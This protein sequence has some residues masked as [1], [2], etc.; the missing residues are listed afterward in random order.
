MSIQE[1]YLETLKQ[2]GY[3]TTV[4]EWAVKFGELHPDLLAQTHSQAVNQKRPSTGLKETAARMSS[5]IAK[6]V[7]KGKIEIDNSERPKKVR[8]LSED[9]ATQHILKEI[10]EDTEPLDRA[11]RIE[12]DEKRLTQKETYRI[13]EILDISKTMSRMFRLDFEVDHALALLHPKEPGAHH[14]DNMQILTKAHNGRKNNSNWAR[15][16]I[17]EQI[18]YINSVIKVQKIVEH[19]MNV[20][21]D[22]A[23]IGNIISRLKLVY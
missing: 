12:Q 19:K 11:E 22:D 18:E 16:T 13:A 10:E 15:F 9:E 23:L 5:L 17:D 6:G 1:K 8:Y 21:L 3:S 4:S 14:P 2:I 7:F 20:E